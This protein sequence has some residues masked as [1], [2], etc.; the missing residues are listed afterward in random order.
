MKIYNRLN[1]LLVTGLSV[2]LS[3]CFDD[4]SGSINTGGS[5]EYG[6]G[7]YN[8]SGDID[9][10]GSG[11]EIVD[12]NPVIVDGTS[13]NPPPRPVSQLYKRFGGRQKRYAPM[14]NQISRR[15]G[16]EP[17]LTHAIISQESAYKPAVGSSA[18]AV[19]LMQ[20]MPYAGRRFGCVNRTNPVCNVNAGV[21][22][23]K[24]LARTFEGKGNIQTIAAGYN[25]GERAAKSYLNGT[26]LA[27]KNPRGRKTPNGVPVAS[28]ALSAKQKVRCGRVNWSP[29][30]QCEGQTY[31][32]ARNVAGYYLRYKRNPGI[33]GIGVTAAKQR[34]TSQA[35]KRRRI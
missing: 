11:T 29:S 22:Y 31:H 1:L 3:A 25:A 4:D 33:I 2:V 34:P 7:T 32:Y 6:S 21:K 12:A 8:N 28:F 35:V 9:Y 15:F 24:F 13:F 20:L 23:L 14:I 17:Y 30:A 5:G 26:K 27:G 18:G 16:V 10:S 19:G